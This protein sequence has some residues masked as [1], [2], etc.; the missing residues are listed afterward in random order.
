MISL[1][2]VQGLIGQWWYAYD[3]GEFT[4]LAQLLTEDVHFQC[5]SDTRATEYEEFIRCDKRGRDSVMEWQTQHRT[6]SPYPLR[7]N[8]TNI[9][10]TSGRKDEA[11]FAS[12]IFVSQIVNR[13]FSPLSTGLVRGTA[14]RVG[15]R[16]LIAALRVTL[17]TMDSVPLAEHLASATAS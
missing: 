2:E 4:T 13:G 16:L 6:A 10:L 9:H 15:D 1:T 11:D 3:Q 7:H 5:E 8:G 12:Y 17:D 14:R